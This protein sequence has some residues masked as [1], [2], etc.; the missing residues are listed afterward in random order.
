M[1][2][3]DLN[4]LCFK[5][6]ER[7]D[8]E[9]ATGSVE[10]TP[11]G[12]SSSVGAT[13]VDILLHQQSKA[14]STDNS[15]SSGPD[16]LLDG[17]ASATAASSPATLPLRVGGQQQQI[18][19]HNFEPEQGSCSSSALNSQGA[20]RASTLSLKKKKVNIAPKCTSKRHL[21]SKRDVDIDSDL[22]LEAAQETTALNHMYN[23]QHG[24]NDSTDS[25]T[26]TPADNY[27]TMS[28]NPKNTTLDSF[29][30]NEYRK[31]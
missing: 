23:F 20:S 6:K 18:S 22:D 12:V 30:E 1:H 10:I 3:S 14:L 15:L 26:T 31:K 2:A 24:L 4:G 8:T 16:M 7:F 29:M 13:T 5:M 28:G 17:S 19:F 27:L 9:S 11:G 21:H 25:R